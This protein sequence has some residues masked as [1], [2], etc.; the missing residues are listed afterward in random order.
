MKTG[1]NAVRLSIEHESIVTSGHGIQF[2]RGV[3]KDAGEY[4]RHMSKTKTAR[5]GMGEDCTF[6][7]FQVWGILRFWLHRF[8]TEIT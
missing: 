3:R 1:S 2:L 6:F 7:V 4:K 8:S 5:A